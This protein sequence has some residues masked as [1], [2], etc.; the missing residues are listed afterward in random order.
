MKK[1]LI[2][3]AHPAQSRSVMNKALREAVEDMENVTVNDLYALYPDFIIDV[4]REQALCLEHDVI[5]FQHPFYWYSTPAILKEWQDLVLE[6]GWAY[7]SKGKTLEGKI[8]F[9]TITAGGDESTYQKKGFN[10]FDLC[11]L[12]TPFQAMAKLC[13]LYWLPP[14]AIL[15]IHRG[16]EEDRIRFFAEEYRRTLCAL[17]DE[18]LNL[19]AASKHQYLNKNLDKVI[20][21]PE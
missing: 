10:Q 20:E 16:V 17:R 11:E 1:I 8:F 7:G 21:R 9:Q 18:R 12:T 4:K 19:K 2:I 13:S 15:G 14:Y 3:Y 5:I 6:H